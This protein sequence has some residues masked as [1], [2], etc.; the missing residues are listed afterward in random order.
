M[1]SEHDDVIFYRR[2]NEEINLKITVIGAGFNTTYDLGVDLTLLPENKIHQVVPFEHNSA[3]AMNFGYKTLKEAR[4]KIVIEGTD[5]KIGEFTIHQ[6]PG[7]H[8]EIF[9]FSLDG[10]RIRIKY[11]PKPPVKKTSDEATIQKGRLEVGKG[12]IGT[13]RIVQKNDTDT[14][15]PF[16][17]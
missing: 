6:P 1:E 3:A 7:T 15:N 16:E 14:E 9:S 10:D 2:D 8:H 5:S 17:S 4:Y 11:P 13:S 12:I